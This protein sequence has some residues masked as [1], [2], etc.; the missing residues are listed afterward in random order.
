MPFIR[1]FKDTVKIGVEAHFDI[2]CSEKIMQIATISD[3]RFKSLDFLN[4][5]TKKSAYRIFKDEMSLFNVNEKSLGGRL[6]TYSQIYIT[7]VH[8][9]YSYIK[10]CFCK[11]LLYKLEL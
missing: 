8:I 9:T 6:I 1:K 11:V 10:Y 3:P 2:D 4:A 5:K 7:Y